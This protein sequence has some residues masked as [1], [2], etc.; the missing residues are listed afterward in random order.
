MKTDKFTPGDVVKLISSSSAVQMTVEKLD[1][2]GDVCCVW[3][4]KRGEL[5]RGDFKPEA[6]LKLGN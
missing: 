2:Y 3:F 5:R 4:N 1:D 6:L